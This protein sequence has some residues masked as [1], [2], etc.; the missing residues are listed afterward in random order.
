LEKLSGLGSLD[1]VYVCGDGMRR[2][3]LLDIG[4]DANALGTNRPAISQ[5]RSSGGL[6][7]TFVRY[8]RENKALHSN[9]ARAARVCDG[10]SPQIGPCENLNSQGE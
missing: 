7:Q 1:D 3:L 6:N 10:D 8:V 5:K 2:V 4:E 9:K